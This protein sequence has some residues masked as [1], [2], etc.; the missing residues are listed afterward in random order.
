MRR[1]ISDLPDSTSHAKG[2]NKPRLPF[3][4]DKPGLLI[5]DQTDSTTLVIS[6]YLLSFQFDVPRHSI[7]EMEPLKDITGCDV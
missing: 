6:L 5:S 3:R 1:S 2:H 7:E 4:F